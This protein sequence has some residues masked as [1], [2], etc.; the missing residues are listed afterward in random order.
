MTQT[1]LAKAVGIS[2][3]YLNLIE[4]NR[5]G[6]AGRTLIALARELGMQPS[7]LTDGAD[8]ALINSLAEVAKTD[9]KISPEID[10]I[11]E[12]VGRYPGWARLLEILSRTTD[13]QKETLTALTDQ[14][15][16]DPFVSETMHQILSNITAI[17]STAS[18]LA[19][20][21]NIP[22]DLS[23]RFLQNL[24]SESH[25]LSETAQKMVDFFD[26]EDEAE[27]RAA[28]T[29]P[30]LEFWASRDYVTEEPPK[31]LNHL[32]EQEAPVLAES[33]QRFAE[34]DQTMPAEEFA[35][36]AQEHEFNPIEI[37]LALNIDLLKVMFRMAQM[38]KN[39]NFP[40]FGLMEVDM[41]G[42]IL[43][44]KPL[45]QLALPLH[46]SGCPLWPV[47]RA[48]AQPNQ[49][50]RAVIEMPS[51]DAVITYSL[52]QSAPPKDYALP[53]NFRSAMIFSADP[54]LL[55]KDQNTTIKAG[56]HCSVCPRNSC[57]ARR[58]DYILA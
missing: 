33:Q 34:I 28:I 30:A 57:S 54:R 23:D 44:R 20:E 1:S 22:K 46:S 45:Q 47:Y 29:A 18:I 7:E 38:P 11:E 55:R 26:R 42:A 32:A 43:M 25:R 36:I 19:T 58:V 8:E 37:S 39:I 6:I 21:S 9:A 40:N 53:P 41:S 50:L 49:I 3:S 12:F 48:F 27:P 17:R 16:H 2:A 5:R 4:H 35:E 31:D 14:L 51:G 56:L 24:H 13:E 52:A 10:R 15:S